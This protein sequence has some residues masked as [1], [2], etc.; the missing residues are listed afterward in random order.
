MVNTV[1]CKS[2]QKSGWNVAQFEIKQPDSSNDEPF[3]SPVF[4]V[5]EQTRQYAV[6]FGT[7][8]T[9]QNDAGKWYFSKSGTYLA[10]LHLG[11]LPYAPNSRKPAPQM[12]IMPLREQQQP[13]AVTGTM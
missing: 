7:I 1:S 6:S 9:K 8:G 4:N 13:S 5:P 10:R 12:D 3:M 11:Q 2:L